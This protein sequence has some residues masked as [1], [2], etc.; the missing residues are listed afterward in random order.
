MCKAHH[1]AAKEAVSWAEATSEECTALRQRLKEVESRLAVHRSRCR[2]LAGPSLPV[3][4]RFL[5]GGAL[6]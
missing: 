6:Q 1:S 3:F 5:W 4:D 2:S